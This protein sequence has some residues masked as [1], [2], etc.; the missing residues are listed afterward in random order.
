MYVKYENFVIFISGITSDIVQIAAA[1]VGKEFNIYIWHPSYQY[2]LKH[3][4]KLDS[5]ILVEFWSIMT[6]SL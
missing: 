6:G 1:F 4:R 5:L 3:L 2:V